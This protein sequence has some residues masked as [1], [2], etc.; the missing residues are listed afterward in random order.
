MKRRGSSSSSTV[1]VVADPS[2][3]ANVVQQLTGMPKPD[4]AENREENN[5]KPMEK[6]LLIKPVPKRPAAE[7]VTGKSSPW[8]S[9]LVTS[10]HPHP[11]LTPP[12]DTKYPS[13]MQPKPQDDLF[14]TLEGI[15]K[16]LEED[17]ILF[18]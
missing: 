12:L 9:S 16:Y 18:D 15:S 7:D 13:I 14:T 5:G 8:L 3:F 10:S 4:I 17:N 6:P 11:L 2:T 1:I